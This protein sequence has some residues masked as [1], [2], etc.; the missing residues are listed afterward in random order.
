MIVELLLVIIGILL[1]VIAF[2]LVLLNFQLREP[3]KVE[4]E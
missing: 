3:K 2:S 1:G 4:K